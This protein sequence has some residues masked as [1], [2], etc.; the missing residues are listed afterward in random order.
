MG[1]VLSL[2]IDSKSAA[3]LNTDVLG[4]TDL[5]LEEVSNSEI[6]LD[7][8][9]APSETVEAVLLGSALEQPLQIAQRARSRDKNLAVLILSPPQRLHRLREAVQFSPFLGTDVRCFS[10]DDHETFLAALQELVMRT[11]QRRA[12][13]TMI[14]EA[15]TRVKTLSPAQPQ[16]AQVL[17]RLLDYAPMGVIVLDD[18]SAIVD[19]AK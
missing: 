17:D 14:A 1:T 16:P 12:Y 15:Q 19:L 18:N 13:R 9:S 6:L 5:S 7:R 11:R 10:E 8:L 3:L 4:Q 2:Q